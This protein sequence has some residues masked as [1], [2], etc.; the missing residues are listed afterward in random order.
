MEGQEIKGGASRCPL[1]LVY[2]ES[3]AVKGVR[4]GKTKYA[5]ETGRLGA[6]NADTQQRELFASKVISL[7]SLQ[8]IATLLISALFVSSP[9]LTLW[10]AQNVWLLYINMILPFV[11]IF[12]IAFS[13]S[14]SG[15]MAGLAGL[16]VSMSY[17][18]GVVCGLEDPMVV[19][20]AASLTFLVCGLLMV[21]AYFGY[22]A[23]YSLLGY[24]PYVVNGLTI[25]VFAGL[26]GL[27]CSPDGLYNYILTVVGLIFFCF[28]LIFN[29][30]SVISGKN[31]DAFRGLEDKGA[32]LAAANIWLNII[33]I[34]LRIL[35]L[36]KGKSK[37]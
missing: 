12:V 11:F 37:Q 5:Y 1:W 14:T 16:T 17:L 27:F 3:M 7:V 30:Q 29:I 35:S 9:A 36:S 32:F 24:A 8:V 10:A 4:L 18:V 22:R 23:G 21:Y 19:Y 31:A 26:I 6:E 20:Q 15:G 34:F 28:V 33:S 25:L 2:C 13:E